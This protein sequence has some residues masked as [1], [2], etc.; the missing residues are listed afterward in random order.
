MMQ[1]DDLR[2]AAQVQAPVLI[3]AE[4]HTERDMCARLIH[5][6]GARGRGPFVTFQGHTARASAA[7]R[8]SSRRSRRSGDNAGLRRQFELARGGTLFIDDIA[9]LTSD[10]QMLLF[11]LLDERV[12]AREDVDAVHGGVRIISGASCPLVRAHPKSALFGSLFYRLNVIH[13]DLSHEGH[14]AGDR[15]PAADR[16]R[17]AGCS[18]EEAD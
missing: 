15:S 7:K 18:D 10:A 4:S 1:Q 6:N 11:S 14:Q 8:S 12:Q 9:D 13:I 3:T 17:H 5:V 2:L 16:R